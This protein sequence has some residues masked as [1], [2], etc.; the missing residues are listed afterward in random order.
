MERG[1]SRGRHG[2]G[3][4]IRSVRGTGKPPGTFY[5]L[6]QEEFRAQVGGTLVLEL[7]LEE[8][9]T[10]RHHDDRSLCLS[11]NALR[12]VEPWV[13]A[14]TSPWI[15]WGITRFTHEGP[16]GSTP[17]IDA[18]AFLAHLNSLQQLVRSAHS[19]DEISQGMGGSRM[20]ASLNS[21]RFPKFRAAF[22]EVLDAIVAWIPP[23]RP[24]FLLGI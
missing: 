23:G 8:G 2:P 13:V 4:A 6:S 5:A 24:F 14:R 18:S 1:R 3:K 10:F 21:K 20:V 17:H 9:G 16:V 11:E 7:A 22:L 12:L 19:L 15:R